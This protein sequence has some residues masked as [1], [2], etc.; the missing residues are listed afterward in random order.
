MMSWENCVHC[1]SAFC[2]G[3]FSAPDLS[4]LFSNWSNGAFKS[5]L[6]G[7]LEHQAG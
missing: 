4:P 1:C 2:E 3:M 7:L 5:N 6:A